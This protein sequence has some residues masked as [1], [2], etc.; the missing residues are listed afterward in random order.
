MGIGFQASF[1]KSNATNYSQLTQRKIHEAVSHRDCHKH[2]NKVHGSTQR[3]PVTYVQYNKRVTMGSSFFTAH[4]LSGKSTRGSW[5]FAQQAVSALWPDV[6]LP[7]GL[8]HSCA[9]GITVS[10]VVHRVRTWWCRMCSVFSRVML[11]S[12]PFI[13]YVSFCN[14]DK[15]IIAEEKLSCRKE[16]TATGDKLFLYASSL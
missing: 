9:S 7:R 2:V 14:S 16:E 11:N 3:A 1:W 13:E 15:S 6:S 4:V 5:R 10:A 12:A 8:T